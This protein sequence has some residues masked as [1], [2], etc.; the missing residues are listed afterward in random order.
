VRPRRDFNGTKTRPRHVHNLQITPLK[1]NILNFMKRTS[2]PYVLHLWA[3]SGL[4]ADQNCHIYTSFISCDAVHSGS[5]SQLEIKLLCLKL[6][7]FRAS[8]VLQATAEREERNF[9]DVLIPLRGRRLSH[10][11][12]RQPGTSAPPESRGLARSLA[13]TTSRSKQRC[14][15]VRVPDSFLRAVPASQWR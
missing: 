7:A 15:K 13:M 5:T 10:T 3:H 11:H 4:I 8:P 6:G 14:C 2:L 12:N 1:R 9:W